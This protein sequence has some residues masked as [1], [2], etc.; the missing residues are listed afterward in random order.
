M[1]NYD[2]LQARWGGPHWFPLDPERHLF[3]FTPTTLAR[4]LEAEG[5]RIERLRTGQWEMDPFGIVQTALNRMGLPRD[6]FFRGLS[7]NA[8]VR[9]GVSFRLRFVSALFAQALALPALVWFAVESLRG[10]G[11]S[12]IVVARPATKP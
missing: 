12:M 2:S 7:A 8:K 11:G 4:L 1:P 9:S 3:H 6:A 10:R 5:F